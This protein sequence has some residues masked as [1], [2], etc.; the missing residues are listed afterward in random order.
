MSTEADKKAINVQRVQKSVAKK[1]AQMNEQEKHEYQLKKKEINRKGQANYVAKKARLAEEAIKVA[2]AEGAQALFEQMKEETVAAAVKERAPAMYARELKAAIAGEVI[3]KAMAIAKE[4]FAKDDRNNSVS[5]IGHQQI[6]DNTDNDDVNNQ[7]IVSVEE[8]IDNMT[9][10]F[11]E[12][13]RGTLVLPNKT[14]HGEDKL[15]VEVL[16]SLSDYLRDNWHSE[17]LSFIEKIGSNGENLHMNGLRKLNG[18]RYEFFISVQDHFAS[19]FRW[20]L[21]LS[22]ENRLNKTGQLDEPY[23]FALTESIIRFATKRARLVPALSDLNFELQNFGYIVSMGNATQ[24]DVHIDLGKHTHFQLGMLC[25]EDS[26]LTCEYTDVVPL[27]INEAVPLLS[28]I[29][30]DLPTGLANKLYKKKGIP[31]LVES[32]GGLLCSKLYRVNK[33]T[34]DNKLPL[35]TLLC[36]PGKVPHCGP[37]VSGKNSLRAVLFFTATPKDD[38]AYNPETQYCRTTL[39][40]EFLIAT[41]PHLTHDERTYMLYKWKTIGLDNDIDAVDVNLNHQHLK[42]MAKAL[43]KKKGKSLETLISKLAN[44]KTWDKTVG[45]KKWMD[46]SYSYVIPK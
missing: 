34:A 39:V 41:W 35:G 20:I 46:E 45:E 32:F 2:V 33:Q 43:A 6:A 24:Q 11:P 17:Q 25:S 4:M 3:D 7:D 10:Q 31:Q 19:A 23:L 21:K 37:Q 16:S 44:E 15:V 36:T 38:T 30:N 5:A 26:H 29:W 40:A 22:E 27:V 42:V 12:Y 14:W 18:N 1:M 28:Q 8:Q 9:G 13:I